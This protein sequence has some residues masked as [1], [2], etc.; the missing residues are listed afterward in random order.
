M[1]VLWVLPGCAPPAAGAAPPS[2]DLRALQRF[3]ADLDAD[4]QRFAAGRPAAVAFD[5]RPAQIKDPVGVRTVMAGRQARSTAFAF[6]VVLGT[7][8]GPRRIVRTIYAPDLEGFVAVRLQSTDRLGSAWPVGAWGRIPAI[9]NT[10][11][12]LV[13][14]LKGR[15]CTALPL[16][17]DVDLLKDH[18]GSPPPRGPGADPGVGF[19]TGSAPR[20]GTAPWP[21][22]GSASTTSTGSSAT[23]TTPGRAPSAEAST[24]PMDGR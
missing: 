7:N 4:L 14:A 20:C 15:E 13:A 12:A 17:T 24:S 11:D 2:L 22:W 10:A 18:L 8:A 9:L 6:E 16:V 23:P 21:C 5:P 1:F 19:A 3:A